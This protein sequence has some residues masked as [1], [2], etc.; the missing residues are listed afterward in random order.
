MKYS[1]L[2]LSDMEVSRLCLG[3]M[4]FGKQTDYV[5]ASEIMNYAL[6]NGINFFDTAEMYPAPASEE[7]FG[8][9]EEF[10]GKWMQLR[11]NRD[12][13]ILATKIT[14]PSPRFGYIS[15]DLSFSKN[16]L[17]SALNGSLKRL[18]TS[19]IDLYQVHWP[20]RK[21]N[22]FGQLGFKFDPDDHWQYNL[23]EVVSTLDDLVKK[24]KIRHWGISNETPWGLM[25]YLNES[26]TMQSS[27]L[28]SIQNPYNLLNRSFEVGLSEMIMREKIG[29]MAYSPLAFGLLTG[30]YHQHIPSPLSRLK[31]FPQ[32]AR[33]S[34]DLAYKLSHKYIEIAQ[35]F[36]LD[37][38]SFALS[39]VLHQPFVS[40]AIVGV[41]NV[42]QLKSLIHRM[43][44]TFQNEWQEDIDAIHTQCSN[45]C[46]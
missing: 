45:P 14:G 30:K 5:S 34:S 27:P 12:K 2:G 40:T 20:E 9:T 4:T 32:M 33:Y 13:I 46:P 23:Q 35:K 39:F 24:G 11:Q 3:T 41:T 31:R 1:R 38:A 16:R 10:I 25:S 22:T 17:E 19:F 18:K 26:R 15:D 28:I 29:M 42:L 37:P 44:W 36:N 43:L 8:V 7:T 6:E 21:T